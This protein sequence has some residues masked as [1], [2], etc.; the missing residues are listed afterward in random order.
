MFKINQVTD[1][2]IYYIKFYT[3]TFEVY[4]NKDKNFEKKKAGTKIL[5]KHL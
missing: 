4:G 3:V 1:L 5:C 2:S